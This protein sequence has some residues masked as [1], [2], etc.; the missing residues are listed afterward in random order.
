MTFD[1]TL[2]LEN[3]MDK[4]EEAFSSL[5]TDIDALTGRIETAE[6]TIFAI[7]DALKTV[8]PGGLEETSSV[9]ADIKA[10]VNAFYVA[11]YG[12]AGSD[13]PFPEPPAVSPE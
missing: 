7:G 6:K 3:R 8:T 5:M 12:P 13:M 2:P 1:S 11:V 4:V 9:I 10:R